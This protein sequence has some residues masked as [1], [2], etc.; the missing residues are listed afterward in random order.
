MECGNNCRQRQIPTCDDD[1][2]RLIVMCAFTGIYFFLILL[3][4][5]LPLLPSYQFLTNTFSI[6][7]FPLSFQAHRGR[8]HELYF[9]EKK[10]LFTNFRHDIIK[11]EERGT[12]SLSVMI[13][14]SFPP[15]SNSNT[16]ITHIKA[17]SKNITGE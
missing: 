8:C 4:Y 12:F 9:R 6:M 5:S 11:E 10:S 16:H 14:F 3:I 15:F 1:D 17:H 2:D 13:F 7:K